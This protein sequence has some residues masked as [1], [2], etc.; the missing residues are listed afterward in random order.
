MISNFNTTKR[1]ILI[2]GCQF[3]GNVAAGRAA[4]IDLSSFP[5]INIQDCRFR[6]NHAEEFEGKTGV[7]FV[8][9]A[10]SVTIE[11]TSI[12]GNF[13]FNSVGPISAAIY[14]VGSG[15]KTTIT[16][17]TIS[18][19]HK[20]HAGRLDSCY[21]RDSRFYR[22]DGNGFTVTGGT[23]LNSQFVQNGYA[24]VEHGGFGN[25]LLISHC[26]IVENGWNSENGFGSGLGFFAD[27]TVDSCIIEGNLNQNNGPGGISVSD[28]NLKL[29]NSVIAGNA[30]LPNAGGAGG[31]WVDNG[32]SLEIFHSTFQGNVG[33]PSQIATRNVGS[34]TIANTIVWDGIESI[35]M[36]NTSVHFNHCD[37]S[38]SQSG[39]GNISLDP[40]FIAEWDGESANLRLDCLSPCLD[41]GVV[42]EDVTRD[43]AGNPRSLGSGPDIGAY[44]NCI[45]DYDGNRIID[46]EDLLIFQPQWH[47]PVSQSNQQFNAN[48]E[49]RSERR[50]DAADLT[51]LLN[52]LKSLDR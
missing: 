14:A 5:G 29:I 6:N 28:A 40:L 15:A 20:M 11:K 22:N 3:H 49:M 16:E 48:H 19:N 17:S 1:E 33:S 21:I 42:I 50:I 26:E 7:L 36:E 46:T 24:G 47:Q 10:Q 27:A 45:Y 4:A 23:I 13:G 37:L 43:L 44:E 32:G 9:R 2:S 8:E 38:Q 12:E 31:L 35:D 52:G 30:S 25:H 41:A 34:A 18:S 39:T 51:G